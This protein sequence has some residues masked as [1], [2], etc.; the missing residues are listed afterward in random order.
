MTASVRVRVLR[1]RA[2]V[3][4]AAGRT[5]A[6]LAVFDRLLAVMPGDRHALASRADLLEVATCGEDHFTRVWFA[7]AG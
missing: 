7:R 2:W 3:A 6:A 4:L 5:D 1:F